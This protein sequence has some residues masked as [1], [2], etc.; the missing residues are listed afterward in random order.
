MTVF[1]ACVH[2]GHAVYLYDLKPR[3]IRPRCGLMINFAVLTK[4]LNLGIANVD[5][6][7]GPWVI[8]E[9]KMH[10][11]LVKTMYSVQ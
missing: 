6:K 8:P 11:S 5:P 9:V 10:A 2:F 3:S 1:S 7:L 4:T